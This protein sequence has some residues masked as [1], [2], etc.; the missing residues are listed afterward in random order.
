M[1]K[2]FQ[3]IKPVSFIAFI[4]LSLVSLSADTFLPD[5][6]SDYEKFCKEITQP[7]AKVTQCLLEH[8]DD[9]S[10]GCKSNLKAYSEKMRNQTKGACK[11]DVNNF[12]KWTVPGGGRIIKCLF[13]NESS[14]S[15]PCRKIL[16]E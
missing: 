7:K 1:N 9:L 12:C 14:L 11:E 4:T 8:N 16:N 10:E 2:M 3:P 15:E 13:R 6:K 5:C